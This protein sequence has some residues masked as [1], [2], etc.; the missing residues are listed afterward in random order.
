MTDKANS[1]RVC[2]Q[3]TFYQARLIIERLG[4]VARPTRR[5]AVSIQIYGS[6]MKIIFQVVHESAP[7][8]SA[9]HAGVNKH[10]YETG[11]GLEKVSLDRW[12]FFHRH[13]APGLPTS[14]L[15]ISGDSHSRRSFRCSR[16]TRQ[17]APEP[18]SVVRAQHG[19]SDLAPHAAFPRARACTSAV[20][21]ALPPIPQSPLSTSW[22]RQKVTM[23]MFSPSIETSASVSL[24]MIWRFCSLLK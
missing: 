6:D 8:A 19:A 23:R 7:H 21:R 12:Q 3:C 13:L 18:P 10:D 17:G 11:S 2:R 4:C 15:S 5:T 14:Q 24:L 9:R 16:E 20:V 1:L 22:T